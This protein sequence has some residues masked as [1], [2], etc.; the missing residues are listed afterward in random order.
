M[1]FKAFMT[2]A[3]VHDVITPN[4]PQKAIIQAIV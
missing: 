1:Y 2:I 3:T 4:M